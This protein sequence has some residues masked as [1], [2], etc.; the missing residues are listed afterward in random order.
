MNRSPAGQVLVLS[1][2]LKK[3]QPR[4][5]VVSEILNFMPRVPKA[6]PFAPD[7]VLLQ[8]VVGSSAARVAVLLE[9][10][11]GFGFDVAVSPAPEPIVGTEEDQVVV[12]NTAILLNRETMQVTGQ[13]GFVASRYSSRDAAPELKPRIKEHAHCLA[14]TKSGGIEV[15]FVSVHFVTNQKFAA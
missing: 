11:T 1:A 3:A 10:S 5:R 8:E 4:D 7:A 14:R 12:R 13:G 6:V 2:N 9:E 15:P